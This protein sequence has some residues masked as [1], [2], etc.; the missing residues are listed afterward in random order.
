MKDSITSGLPSKEQNV[1][2]EASGFCV[3]LA[4]SMMGQCKVYT[5]GPGASIV[6]GR[7][8]E[9]SIARTGSSSAKLVVVGTGS[10]SFAPSVPTYP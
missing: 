7:N 4:L 3:Q 5:L 9:V 1:G 6:N 8:T 10:V 2:V